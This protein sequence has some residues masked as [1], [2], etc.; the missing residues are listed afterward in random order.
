MKKKVIYDVDGTIT[1]DPAFYKGAMRGQMQGGDEVHVVTGNSRAREVLDQLGFAKGR[2]FTTLVQVPRK[3]IAH[4]KV[5]YMRHV[6][7]TDI[8]DN[9][10]KTIKRAQRAGFTA[11]WHRGPK[12]KES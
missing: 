1:A 12:A 8:V 5:A 10:G 4:V 11:H 2:E 3:H 9:H 6:G 7:A